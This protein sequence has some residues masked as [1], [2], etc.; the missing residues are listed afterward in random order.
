MAFGRKDPLALARSLRDAAQAELSGSADQTAAL[1]TLSARFA[2][3]LTLDL[4][5]IVLMSPEGR[6]HVHTNK[7]REGRVYADPANLKAAAVRVETVERYDRNTGEVVR[8]AIVPVVVDGAHHSVLRVGQVVPKGSLD[9]TR[10]RQHRC[11]G[12]GPDPR[13]CSLRGAHRDARRRCGRYRDRD[14][15]GVV[16]HDA[17]TSAARA[18]SRGRPRGDGRRPHRHGRTAAA[19]TSSVRSASS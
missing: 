9:R 14:G 10:C 19:V 5:Y 15:P 11:R 1:S 6:T 17:D 18:F 7:L 12:C 3:E 8:E 2:T 13:V 4:E 16:E